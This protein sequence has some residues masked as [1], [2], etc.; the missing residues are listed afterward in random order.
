MD[1]SAISITSLFNMG[2]TNVFGL[3]VR[4][5]T[6][7]KANDVVLIGIKFRVP[8]GP[9]RSGYSD[10]R[11]GT[12][13]FDGIRTGIRPDP[14]WIRTGPRVLSIKRSSMSP[15]AKPLLQCLSFQVY[16]CS[17]MLDDIIYYI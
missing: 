14:T 10:I 15:Y 5:A 1:L 7:A 9:D 6:L 3:R 12:V 8:H 17:M 13:K 11:S 16:T 4:V 2:S